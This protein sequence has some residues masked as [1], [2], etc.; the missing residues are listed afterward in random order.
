MLNSSPLGKIKILIADDSNT[1]R[2]LLQTILKKQ[3]HEVV[4][5]S[6]GLE[7]VDVF[8]AQSPSIVLMDALMP[9][10]DGFE[11]AQKIKQ[12]AGEDFVPI[13]FLTSLQEADSLARCLDAGGDDFLSKP[14][15]SVILQAKINAFS[16]M[17]EMHRTVKSQRDEI[18]AHN[19]RLLREQEVAKRV[20]D[21]VAHEGCLDASNIK[22]ALSPIAIFNGDVALAGV[23]SAGHLVVLLGDFTG[24]GLD[25]AIGAMP[26]AQSFYSMLEKGFSM[27]DILAEINSKLHEVLPVGVFCCAIMAEINFTAATMRVWNG[28]LPDA[29]IYRPSSADITRLASQHL[30]L[31]VRAQLDF[32]NSVMT[33]GIETDDRL[34]LW[35]D[36]IHEATNESGE[37]FGEPR[38]V[39]VFEDNTDAENLFTELNIAVNSFIAEDSVGDDISLVEVKM[40]PPEQF[41]VERP[42]IIGEQQAGPRDWSLNYQLRPDTLRD[43]DPL[44]MLLYV[45]MSVPFLR[46]SGGQIYTVMAE[47]YANALEHGVLKLESA[48]KDSTEGF[49]QY[50]QLRKERLEQLTEG[51]ISVELDYK[52]SRHGG[53][54]RIIVEDSGEGFNHQGLLMGS[55][56]Q[57]YSGR[58]IN[59]L[60]S[61]CESVEFFGRGNRVCAT[62]VWGD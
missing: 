7:A 44:P 50:Y 61:I 62:F 12:L 43:F 41:K 28:G 45:L 9:R 39:Q 4:V 30:P 38:L 40:V 35:S 33:Y 59:L 55:P 32:N 53:V 15:N 2:L 47:L 17:R 21:K 36:G 20:F 6:D 1:D 3:G 18:S 8:L 42:Q 11:A 14:Y 56:D 16:R 27:Q 26:L 10:M 58:G 31:G 57:P 46:N 49:N 34:Y 51:L 24:H 37:M 52:G 19:D 54:L 22:Y 13:I 5:A 29:F 48:M 25:A 60:L 23:S